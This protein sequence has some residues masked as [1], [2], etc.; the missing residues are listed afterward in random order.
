MI[1][2]IENINSFYNLY[3]PWLNV[4]LSDVVKAMNWG[5][6]RDIR[7]KAPPLMLNVIYQGYTK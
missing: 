1:D 2:E 7:Q 5:S 3:F 6:N 4:T